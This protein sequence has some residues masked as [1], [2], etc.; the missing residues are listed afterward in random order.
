MT[1]GVSPPPL[2]APP[3]S[4]S[5]LDSI[6]V[7]CCCNSAR[8]IASSALLPLLLL[9]LLP[10]AVG[11]DTVPT[12]LTAPLPALSVE[13]VVAVAE[14]DAEAEAEAEA[15]EVAEVVAGSV[16]AR[17]AS[18]M[19]YVWNPSFIASSAVWP[20]QYSKP[21]PTTNTC[22]ILACHHTTQTVQPQKAKGTSEL[23][24]RRGQVTRER[25]ERRKEEGA[26][27]EHTA[28]R[29]AA[30]SLDEE[31]GSEDTKPDACSTS[32]QN[33]PKIAHHVLCPQRQQQGG[34]SAVLGCCP[35]LSTL[36]VTSACKPAWSCAPGVPAMQCTGHSTHCTAALD[37]AAE[38]VEAEEADGSAMDVPIGWLCSA[39]L[40][41][42]NEMC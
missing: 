13:V 34:G 5:T 10:E 24:A 39:T 12:T 2:P 35:I 40:E 19:T 37:A 17:D 3:L 14:A 31:C 8:F 26:V 29:M 16:S 33:K 23:H 38:E 27:C 22:E 6:T 9:L 1:R 42:W 36:S 32:D 41:L 18:V 7:T 15:E 4:S 28:L 20:N 30:S 11:V 25:S 21:M